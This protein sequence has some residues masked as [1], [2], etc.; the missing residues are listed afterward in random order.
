[1]E[2]VE[3]YYVNGYITKTLVEGKQTNLK[4]GVVSTLLDSAGP[5]EKSIG[6][7]VLEEKVYSFGISEVI[8]GITVI[9]TAQ[10]VID[11]GIKTERYFSLNNPAALNLLAEIYNLTPPL[12][13]AD[14]DSLVADFNG[15]SLTNVCSA[16]VCGPVVASVKFD[17][18][19]KPYML[20]MYRGN[21]TPTD[22]EIQEAKAYWSNVPS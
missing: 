1:M 8:N 13:S 10:T 22:L 16:G 9:G 14:L 11:T 20:K 17:E 2:N 15:W 19:G 4:T 18:D 3:I 21:Y 12:R 7:T 5:C 6:N